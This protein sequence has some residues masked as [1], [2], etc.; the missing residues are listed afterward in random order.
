MIAQFELICSDAVS[1]L[2]ADEVVAEAPV[3]YMAEHYTKLRKSDE[4][5]LVD[6]RIDSV[7]DNPSGQQFYDRSLSGRKPIS[8]S[9]IKLMRKKARIMQHWAIKIGCRISIVSEQNDY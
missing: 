1:V 6:F 9:I 7:P 5:K 3:G 4:F 8:S 2:I